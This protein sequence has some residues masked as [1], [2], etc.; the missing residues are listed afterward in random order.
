MTRYGANSFLS[1]APVFVGLDR[2]H[3][4][5]IAIATNWW[6]AYPVSGLRA[7]SRRPTS[8]RI[9][10]RGF[11]PYPRSPCG[12][13]RRIDMD[14]RCLVF[15][16]WLADVLR[17]ECGVD[18]FTFTYGTDTETYT[19]GPFDEREPGLVVLYARRETPRRAV[20]L[21]LAGLNVVVEQR[22]GT[23]VVLFGSGTAV[24][25]SPSVRG[26]RRSEAVGSRSPL[27]LGECRR[28]PVDDQSVAR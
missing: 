10:S 27:S 9:S 2:F 1:D 23:R 19:F 12:R 7:V 28:G 6:T 21:A 18:A 8:S 3:S 20:E 25:A 4:A 16:P 17:S 11:I 14:L 22:P 24:G 5:D 26:R 13:A 15:T